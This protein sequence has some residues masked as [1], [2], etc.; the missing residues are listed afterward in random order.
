MSKTGNKKVLL[1]GG[2]AGIG[3][4][5]ALLLA[6]NAYDVTVVGRNAAKLKSLLSDYEKTNKAG[7]LDGVLVDLADESAMK[8]MVDTYFDS[9]GCPDILIN[10]VGLAYDSVLEEKEFSIDYLLRTNLG[11]YM[12]LSG[13]IANKMID[14][15]LEGD[16]V[17]IGS[18]S[19]DVRGAGSS[20][21][22]ATKSG[23]QG[24]TASFRKEVN[25]HNIRVSLIEPGAV[26]SDMQPTSNKEQQELHEKLE[27][28]KGEDIAQAVL[29]IIQ[30]P[31]RTSI[32]ELHIKP[33][34]QFI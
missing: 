8:K 20:A 25:P 27:M 24:F 11:S 14:D 26:A 15:G 13:R 17:N 33:L 29:F 31:R 5:M 4:S 28:L 10:N 16:I 18:M 34:R 32:V 2:T 22:V 9:R 23:I 1:T 6:E 12:W 7:K 19:A 30:Q 3:R 21:Y